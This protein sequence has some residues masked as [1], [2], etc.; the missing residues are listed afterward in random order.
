M[1]KSVEKLLKGR[2][3]H[4]GNHRC[5]DKTVN[6]CEV[7]EFIYHNTAICTVNTTGQ[8]FYIDNGGWN[9]QSTNRAIA[10]YRRWFR[11]YDYIEVFDKFYALRDMLYAVP[12]DRQYRCRFGNLFN[13][14]FELTIKKTELEKVKI[15]EIVVSNQLKD[16]CTTFTFTYKGEKT[17]NA[18]MVKIESALM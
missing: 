4:E 13:P 10:D 2:S 5:V 16:D 6:N 17:F 15:A 1:L 8:M 3:T 12:M 14:L 18:E 11:N 9:T 7:T